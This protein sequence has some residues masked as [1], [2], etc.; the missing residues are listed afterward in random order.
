MKLFGCFKNLED[1]LF[2]YICLPGAGDTIGAT[3]SKQCEKSSGAP[4]FCGR[5]RM[6]QCGC[7]MS[8]SFFSGCIWHIDDDSCTVI[9]VL[10]RVQRVIS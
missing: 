8:F 4:S 5:N 7:L 3:S 1:V 9:M 2:D 10:D 6:K